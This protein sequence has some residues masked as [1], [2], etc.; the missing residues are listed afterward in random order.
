VVHG[1]YHHTDA[2]LPE[3]RGQA[4]VLPGGAFFEIR[5]GRIARVTN[6]YNLEDWIARVSWSVSPRR[7]CAAAMPYAGA[8][9]PL[10]FS[11]RTALPQRADRPPAHGTRAPLPGSAGHPWRACRYSR[12]IATTTSSTSPH[13]IA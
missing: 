11:V 3:A 1:L 9:E 2:G 8:S 5:D 7:R 4:Y 13:L 6:Y 12:M 10:P